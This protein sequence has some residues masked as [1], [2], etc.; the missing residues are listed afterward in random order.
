MLTDDGRPVDV[1]PQPGLAFVGFRIPFAGTLWAIERDARAAAH[2]LTR[3][4]SL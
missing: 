4:L 2:R 3:V 1:M